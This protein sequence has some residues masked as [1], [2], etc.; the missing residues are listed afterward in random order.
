MDTPK[1][2]AETAASASPNAP[3]I[4]DL[5]T[6]GTFGRETVKLQ[7]PF[8]FKGATYSEVTLRVPTGL[9][10][11]KHTSRTGAVDDLGMMCDLAELSADVFDAMYAGDRNRVDA[12][13]GKHLMGAP[14]TSTS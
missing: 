9:D 1:T 14:A 6:G 8:K 12:A 4:I 13:V 5:D 3:A 7:R 10:L 2:A 11:K